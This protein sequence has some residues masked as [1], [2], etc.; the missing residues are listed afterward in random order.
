M[1]QDAKTEGVASEEDNT[2]TV[3]G[4]I[5]TQEGKKPVSERRGLSD[6]WPD[7][8]PLLERYDP[9]NPLT[10]EPFL[11]LLRMRMLLGTS[12]PASQPVKVWL[13]IWED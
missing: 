10:R 4:F 7:R 1:S 2:T 3:K 5:P 8:L 6:L 11:V 9:S 12:H 13:S